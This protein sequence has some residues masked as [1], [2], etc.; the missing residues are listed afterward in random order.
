MT[1]KVVK[2]D[3]KPQQLVFIFGTNP[4][5]M[6]TVTVW[7]DGRVYDPDFESY[8]PKYNFSIEGKKFRYD[9][10]D[11]NGGC[12]EAPNL[13]RAASALFSFLGAAVEA[14]DNEDSDNHGIFPPEVV[15]WADQNEN[16]IVSELLELEA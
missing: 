8:R 11:I 9:S 14:G 6:S 3:G 5:A 12:N 2:E 10:N 1:A 15:E 13:Y 4:Q 7:C 16:E